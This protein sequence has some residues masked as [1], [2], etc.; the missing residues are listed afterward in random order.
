MVLYGGVA[1]GIQHISNNSFSLFLS[2]KSLDPHSI[3]ISR[4]V[5]CNRRNI[6]YQ[7]YFVHTDTY[8]PSYR[9]FPSVL[10]I[11]FFL[12]NDAIFSTLIPMVLKY[13][14]LLVSRINELMDKLNLKNKSF[15][16]F[17]P[18]VCKRCTWMS[19][20]LSFFFCRS[21]RSIWV[22]VSRLSFRTSNS[23][24]TSNTF[25]EHNYNMVK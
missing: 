3:G 15:L 17:P 16:D 1:I 4:S 18:F 19:L 20:A 14:Y 6:T 23:N 12:W 2:G 21:S 7:I 24:S 13:R 11:L 10:G 8:R 22:K 9:E 25:N 5:E